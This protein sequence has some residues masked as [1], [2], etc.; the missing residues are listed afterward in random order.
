MRKEGRQTGWASFTERSSKEWTLPPM[1]ML[2]LGLQGLAP[3]GL[4]LSWSCDPELLLRSFP[5]AWN[6]TPCSFLVQLPVFS[7]F[8]IAGGYHSHVVGHPSTRE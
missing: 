3:H 2:L 4:I 7:E 1:E 6:A 5:R 8:S